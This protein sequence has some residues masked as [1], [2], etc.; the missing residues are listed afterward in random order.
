MLEVDVER[1]REIDELWSGIFEFRGIYGGE[2]L[3]MYL[4]KGV[5]CKLRDLLGGLLSLV[6]NLVDWFSGWLIGDIID[7]PMLGGSIKIWSI[8]GGSIN[9]NIF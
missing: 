1:L 5:V 7:I 2:V 8:N 4:K 3:K 6:D 9:Q